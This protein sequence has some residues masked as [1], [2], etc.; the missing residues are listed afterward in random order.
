MSDKKNNREQVEKKEFAAYLNETK[1]WET[2]KVEAAEKS[3]RTAWRVA[4]G[5]SFLA[6]VAVTGISVMG[7]LKKVEPYV[8]RVDN[9][10][11]IV[12]VVTAMKDGKTTY[13]EAMN[14]FF[15][16]RY[17]HFRE[18]YTKALA[19]EYY[20]NV[21]L[22]SGTA[23]QQKYF[24]FFTPKNPNSPLNVYGEFAKVRVNIKSTS[25]IKSDVALVRYIKEIE[26][27][28]DKA[29]SHWAATVTFTY[30]KAP[31]SEKDREINP[32]GFIVTDYRNDPEGTDYD[33]IPAQQ[34]S[35]PTQEPKAVTLYPAQA[36]GERS[37]Q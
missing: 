3:R 37:Q 13:D 32:L 25:F 4:A 11:G 15:I 27:G 30:V 5:A 1:T 20:N 8:I 22:M 21:G 6:L 10:T 16:Q 2:S 9:T 36:P 18:G 28:G 34:T 35:A 29:V 23:E 24:A 19:S 7:P 17:V 14:K 31:I 12:D 26:R 33:V